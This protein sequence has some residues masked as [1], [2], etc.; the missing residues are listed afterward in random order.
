MPYKSNNELPPAVKNGL[1]AAAQTIFRNAF[2]SAENNPDYSG[3]SQYMQIAWGAVKNAGYK[4]EGNSWVKKDS[5]VVEKIA[6]HVGIEKVEKK[7]RVFGWGY[8]S[9]KGDLEVVDNS[10]ESCTVEEIEEGAYAFNKLEKRP[11]GVMHLE[12]DGDLIESM[13]FT[14]EKYEAM[15]LEPHGRPLGWWVGFEFDPNGETFA[16]VQSGELKMFSFEGSGI[17]EMIEDVA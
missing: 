6:L 15:G 12:D 1:P 7:G 10:E 11:G 3:E 2:N 13:V 17:K 4:K 14:K 5:P 16:K 9:N 8:V